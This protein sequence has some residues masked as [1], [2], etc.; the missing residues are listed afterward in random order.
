MNVTDRPRQDVAERVDEVR[1]QME[2]AQQDRDAAR[3]VRWR[4]RQAYER[5]VTRVERLRKRGDEI[6]RRRR[7]ALDEAV[8]SA[9]VTSGRSLHSRT[10]RVASPCW[11]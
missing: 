1:E 11:P 6:E 8:S 9:A 3:N 5:A 2:A 10:T 7:T 4:E